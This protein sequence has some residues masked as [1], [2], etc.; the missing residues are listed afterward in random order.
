M[1]D[2]KI[3]LPDLKALSARL[4]KL[5]DSQ[6]K[7]MMRVVN[8]YDL[9]V[10][11]DSKTKPPRVPV[12]TGALQSTGHTEP[13]KIEGSLILAHVSYGGIADDGTTVDY[14]VIV[15]D[16]M[17]GRI[18]NYKRPGSGPKFLETHIHAR[19]P[20]LNRDLEAALGEGAEGL[21]G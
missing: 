11:R 5:S 13:A 8:I 15:H 6:R 9:N 1:L 18:K 14:A 16:N 3:V 4:G 17:N 19:R 2:F 10:L 21:F 7:A 12:D 20:Q